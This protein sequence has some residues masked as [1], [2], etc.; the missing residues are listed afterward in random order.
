MKPAAPIRNCTALKKSKRVVLLITGSIVLAAC[1][2]RPSIPLQQGSYPYSQPP[3]GSGS[4]A[5]SGTAPGQSYNG[6]YNQSGWN[7]GPG[8]YPRGVSGWSGGYPGAGYG[9]GYSG[10]N[11]AGSES[12]SSARGGFGSHGGGSFGS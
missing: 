7:N 10:G 6:G 5:S 8:Y 1:D 12:T 2:N 11:S 9:G 4:G 3:Y